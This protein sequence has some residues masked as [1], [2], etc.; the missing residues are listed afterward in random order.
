MIAKAI[1]I[2]MAAIRVARGFWRNT[3]I[4]MDMRIRACRISRLSP[5]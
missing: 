4:T 1:G 2:A 3:K 5:E